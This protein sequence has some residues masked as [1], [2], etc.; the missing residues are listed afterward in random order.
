MCGCGSAVGLQCSQ[1]VVW[2]CVVREH[3]WLLCLLDR[4]NESP[5]SKVVKLCLCNVL[6][7]MINFNVCI[8]K[9]PVLYFI[10]HF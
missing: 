4:Q 7:S 10:E 2:C 3:E 5:S 8:T 1:R 6:W 9:R